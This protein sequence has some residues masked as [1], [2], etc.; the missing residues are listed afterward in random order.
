MY[1]VFYELSFMALK[2]VEVVFQSDLRDGFVF[3]ID[4]RSKLE[5][6]PL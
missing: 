5:R 6:S 2:R 1:E 4:I 3:Q